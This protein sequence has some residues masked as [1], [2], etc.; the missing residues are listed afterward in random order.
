MSRKAHYKKKV[1][2]VESNKFQSALWLCCIVLVIWFLYI[3]TPDSVLYAKEGFLRWLPFILVFLVLPY[4]LLKFINSVWP[5][6]SGWG[7]VIAA[8]SVLIVGPAFGIISGEQQQK[9]LKKNGSLTKGLVVEKWKST[10]KGNKEWL[11]V[12][13]YN[14]NGK[15]Y[16]TF[17]IPDKENRFKLGDTVTV[18]YSYINPT[19]S[20]VVE[21]S[22]FNR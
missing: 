22:D 6:N 1:K 20:A 4:L 14:A 2:P 13:K 18:L 7:I 11:I 17:S 9:E 5:N 8:A 19:N 21:L 15:A 10:G 12:C 16:T 3:D